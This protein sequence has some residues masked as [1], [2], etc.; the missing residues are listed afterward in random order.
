MNIRSLVVGSRSREAVRFECEP[1]KRFVA[2]QQIMVVKK[3][4]K[5]K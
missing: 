4:K 3:K 5:K 2:R 1:I